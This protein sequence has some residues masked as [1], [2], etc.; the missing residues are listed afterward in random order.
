MP[1]THGAAECEACG[2][3]WG[4]EHQC[5]HC[6]SVSPATAGGEFRW[7][8]R[9]CG[10]IRLPPRVARMFGS[11]PDGSLSHVHRSYAEWTRRARTRRRALLATAVVAP[12]AIGAFCARV[13]A[14]ADTFKASHVVLA[15]FFSALTLVVAGAAWLWL[16]TL[17][18][19]A[20]AAAL[21]ERGELRRT[22]RRAVSMLAREEELTD[23]EL[24]ELVQS[25][26]DIR[27]VRLATGGLT[28]RHARSAPATPH[29]DLQPEE[30]DEG[31]ASESAPSSRARER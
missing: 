25:T 19:R 3:V 11:D 24:A 17:S 20:D 14:G 2:A 15:F 29:G 31:V 4:Q 23:D 1:A 5:P 6:A 10:G 28:A 8:C 26:R 22:Y 18:D 21:D 16:R 13:L 7:T 27:R 12:L 9:D 30:T